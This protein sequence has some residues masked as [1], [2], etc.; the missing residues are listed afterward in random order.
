MVQIQVDPGL[1]D[2]CGICTYACSGRVYRTRESR[3]PSVDVSLC[4][5]CGHCVAAC[6][7]GAISHSEYPLSSCPRI[8]NLPD[9]ETLICAFQTRRSIRSFM[10][11]AVPRDVLRQLL[12]TSR[13]APTGKNLQ[14]VD[15]LVL[16][17][18]DELREL[19]ARVTDVLAQTAR[20]LANPIVRIYLA[21][22]VGFQV[23]SS[24]K[25]FAKDL[26]GLQDRQKAGQDP[27]FYDAPVVA[28]AH[29]P[30]GSYFG[31]YDAVHALYN[32]ELAAERLGLGT[33]PMGYLKIALD[34]SRSLRQYLHLGGNRSPEAALAIGYPRITYNRSLPRRKPAIQWH[35]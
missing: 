29:V 20:L 7:V 6:P 19:T 10:E 17:S 23:V 25:Q 1:C 14:H 4:W 5:K 30:A 11:E 34:R 35:K 26:A 8:E 31:R 32:V 2:G 22:S 15:W 13:Y 9:F 16:D 21:L 28:I 33:C 27:I 12:E 3:T 24:G 18:R